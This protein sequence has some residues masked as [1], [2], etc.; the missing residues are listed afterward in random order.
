MKERLFLTDETINDLFHDFMDT[1]P[2][3]LKK[4]LPLNAA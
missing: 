2:K 4:C 3:S 1:I